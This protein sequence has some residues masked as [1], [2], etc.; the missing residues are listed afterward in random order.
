MVKNCKIKSRPG[1]PGQESPNLKAQEFPNVSENVKAVPTG[2][3][4]YRGKSD[5]SD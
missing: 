3:F 1:K 5:G 2:A 4:R